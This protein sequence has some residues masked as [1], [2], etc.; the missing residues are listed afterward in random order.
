MS[1]EEQ[2]EKAPEAPPALPTHRKSANFTISIV[3]NISLE[4]NEKPVDENVSSKISPPQIYHSEKCI[5][6][7]IS[8]SKSNYLLYLCIFIIIGIILVSINKN[9][10]KSSQS[11]LFSQHKNPSSNS[12]TKSNDI[13]IDISN[14]VKRD[15][16]IEYETLQ[17]SSFEDGFFLKMAALREVAIQ[18]TEKSFTVH[19][20]REG[21]A[22]NLRAGPGMEFDV[23]GKIPNRYAGIKIIQNEPAQSEWV[24]INILTK[25][26]YVNGWVHRSYL[27][28]E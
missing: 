4:A 16:E 21:N 14:D 20:L 27:R 26:G 10:L 13:N 11:E 28:E 8:H 22:L 9:Y 5:P 19:C 25:Q 12:N 17:L 6:D 2:F 18:N 1:C 23:I 15:S 24:L 3:D 7:N